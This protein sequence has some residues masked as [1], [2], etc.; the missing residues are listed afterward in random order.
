MDGLPKIRRIENEIL[1]QHNPNVKTREEFMVETLK[2]FRKQTEIIMERDLKKII[3]SYHNIPKT[4][5]LVLKELVKIN[6]MKDVLRTV[7]ITGFH[8]GTKQARIEFEKTK[9]KRRKQ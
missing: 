6:P 4:E 2:E 8:E 9:E 1:Y 7:W 3:K 5:Y